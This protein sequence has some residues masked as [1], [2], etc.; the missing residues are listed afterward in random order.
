MRPR[1]FASTARAGV[2][3][4][5]GAALAAAFVAAGAS[6]ASASAFSVNPTQILLSAKTTSALLALRNESGEALRF[7]LA[8]FAWSQSPT[9]EM[10][11]QPTDD[12]VFFPTLLTLAPRESRNVRVGLTAPPSALEKTYRIFV[13][14]LPPLAAP[15]ATASV[16]VLTK[17][18]VPIFF[19]PSKPDAQGRLQDVGLRDGIFTFTLSNTGTV[20]F[21]PQSVR[22]RGAD[23]G[24]QRVLDES[25]EAWYVLAGT[26]RKFAVKLPA[27]CAGATVLTVEVQVGTSMLRERLDVPPGACAP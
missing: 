26:V 27:A 25:E 8:V 2:S 22:V 18:G 15:G 13:E 19:E 16:R 21:L 24:G 23:R 3:R 5:R 17:M 1:L 20:H 9:G 12:V 10:Q 14:E 4:L 6:S 11:L 7:Q